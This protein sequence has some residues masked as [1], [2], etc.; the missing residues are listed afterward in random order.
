[1]VANGRSVHLCSGTEQSLVSRLGETLDFVTHAF[2]TS[3]TYNMTSDNKAA[4]LKERFPDGFDYA[5]NSTQDFAVWEAAQSAYA[6]RPPTAAEVTT[7]A[8]L[9]P[10]EILE[11][12]PP[13]PE[14]LPY[15][16]KGLEIWKLIV[17][18]VPLLLITALLGQ[19]S[20][21]MLSLTA[22]VSVLFLANNVGRMLRG[23]QRDR[24]RGGVFKSANAIATGDLSVPLAAIIY[25]V[26]CLV[27]LGLLATV[28]P[29]VA[30][31]VITLR[32][33]V[34]LINRLR[35]GE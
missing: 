19:P 34:D 26:L 10:V 25:I 15:L 31:I 23:V 6:I 24:R 16:L 5:G 22:G 28:S 18:L 11:D 14:A 30:G 13:L 29:Y 35:S 27:G 20:E 32:L 9:Q 4:F 7:T 2:G 8:G 33:G 21:T 1:A 12:R 3:P 17:L